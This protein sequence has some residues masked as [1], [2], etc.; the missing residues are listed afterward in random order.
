[1]AKLKPFGYQLKVVQ[2]GS[3][4]Q[5]YQY[6]D[7]QWR[8]LTSKGVSASPPKDKLIDLD[9]VPVDERLKSRGKS[10]I[11]ARNH[12]MRLCRSNFTTM[13]SKFLTLTFKEPMTDISLANKE[14][15]RFMQ[16]LKRN[17][18]DKIIKYL[19]VIEFQKNGSIHYHILINMPYIKQ[20][21]L[22]KMWGRGSV[23]IKRIQR[24]ENLGLYLVKNM[25]VDDADP[26]MFGKRSYFPSRNLTKPKEFTGKRAEDI[27]ERLQKE[28]R[29]IAYSNTYKSKLQENDIFYSEYHLESL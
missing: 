22:F 24:V 9:A 2:S 15:G 25:T 27:L 4:I 5:V 17:V 1:M 6:T 29:K 18:G 26:R 23:T 19:A 28:G 10:N 21:Q 12:V 7:T 13:N 8:N 14:F 11:R 20:D 3:M 16:N